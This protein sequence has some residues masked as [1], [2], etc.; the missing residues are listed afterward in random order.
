MTT[1]VTGFEPGL[2]KLEIDAWENEGGALPNRALRYQY[3]RRIESDRSW[4]I[5]HV[6]TGDPACIDGHILTDLTRLEAAE[7]LLMLNW[8]L[9]S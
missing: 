7:K 8:A 2:H 3:G 4:T 1:G 9:D 6:F 5:Y